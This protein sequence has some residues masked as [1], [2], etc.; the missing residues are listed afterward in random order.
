[1]VQFWDFLPQQSQAS[2]HTLV[3]DIFESLKQLYLQLTELI[4]QNIL[5]LI[6]TLSRDN[7]EYSTTYSSTVSDII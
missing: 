7:D 1:L 5:K 2:H 3:K 6:L 4:E